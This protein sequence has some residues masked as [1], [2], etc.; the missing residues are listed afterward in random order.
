MP[1]IG[2][3]NIN[4]EQHGLL[5]K[6][7]GEVGEVR[8]FATLSAVR[9]ERGLSALAIGVPR[10]GDGLALVR[11]AQS[12][13]PGSRLI[14]VS[15]T[16]GDSNFLLECMRS[17]AVDVITPE[18]T[19]A[20]IQLR[21][22]DILAGIEQAGGNR[23]RA[24]AILPATAGRIGSAFATE[25]AVC[26]A[27]SEAWNPGVLLLDLSEEASDIDLR[28]NLA[29]IYSVM[30]GIR[31]LSRLDSHMLSSV[32]VSRRDCGLRYM[33]L[34]TTTPRD[35]DT[36]R[37]NFDAL[38][39]MLTQNYGLVLV[40]APAPRVRN[41]VREEL[42]TM[43]QRLFVCEQ[44]LAAV[45][46]IKDAMEGLREAGAN[47]DSEWLIVAEQAKQVPLRPAKMAEA[48]GLSLLKTLPVEHSLTIMAANTGQPLALS[49]SR[50][51]YV[52]ALRGV[53]DRLPGAKDAKTDQ[54]RKSSAAR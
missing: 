49:K 19:A 46:A 11:R 42:A 54:R 44:E 32:V 25:L 17:G 5:A 52:K 7:F 40:Y 41:A 20:S 26:A 29:P 31:D 6:A 23:G 43:V 14:I 24:V 13:A 21:V 36:L 18:D 34:G 28:L 35:L 9:G 51:P 39:S 48:L 3:V 2:I 16:V 37:L 22:G 47:Q 8:D 50:G 30:D 10:D 15:D 45:R 12:I 33:Q 4:G 38:L 53:V 1:T 27:Q